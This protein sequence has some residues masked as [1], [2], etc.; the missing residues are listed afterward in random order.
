MKTRDREATR[1]RLLDA[2]RTLFAEHGYEQVT[3]R[4]IATAADANVALVARYFGS[5]AELFGEVVMG[6]PGIRRVFGGDPATLSRRVAEYAATRMHL[7]PESPIL[8]SLERSAGHPEVQ[9][10]I[11]ERLRNAIMEPLAR[12]LGG[13]HAMERARLVTAIFLGIGTVRR[14]VGPHVPSTAEVDR[15]TAVFEQALTP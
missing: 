6:E 11:R 3:V 2:A 13:A 9:A 15:L 4:M 1:Q 14:M 10:I 7:E 8:R 12:H 5:K